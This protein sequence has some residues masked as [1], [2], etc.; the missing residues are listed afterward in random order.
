MCHRVCFRLA[1]A[2]PPEEFCC[3]ID[4]TPSTAGIPKTFVIDLDA[5]PN[6]C[7]SIPDVNPQSCLDTVY[8]GY[9]QACCENVSS[10]NG[11]VSWTATFDPNPTCVNKLVCCITQRSLATG[12][13][14]IPNPGHGYVDGT[15]IGIVLRN[16]S[17]IV[18]PSGIPG[19]GNDAQITYTVSGGVVTTITVLYGGLYQVIP[20]IIIPSPGAG[21]GNVTA[22]V[23]V[24]IPCNNQADQVGFLGDCKTSPMDIQEANL[25]LGECANMCFPEAY[26][27]LY[28]ALD[29]SGPPNTTNYSYTQQGCCDCSTCANFIVVVSS[30]LSTVD[31]TYTRCSDLSGNY[32]EQVL[33]SVSGSGSSVITCAVPGSIYST[34]DPN[35]IIS[36][37]YHAPC[38]TCLP[39]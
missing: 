13:F 39:G 35:A 29:L 32:A 4:D 24:V 21:M 15:Y 3:L 12:T 30:Q 9:V 26:P 10:N 11:R 27:F 16:P 17:D 31:L 7:P 34:N 20:Q 23:V 37:T 25:L 19:V 6:L 18:P 5:S 1:G 14:Y 22:Q 33:V 2:S 28:N 36:I 38:S 8:E